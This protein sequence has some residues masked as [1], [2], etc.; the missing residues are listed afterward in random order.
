MP[1]RQKNNTDHIQDII[2]VL[3][4][5]DEKS[6]LTIMSHLHQSA[7]ENLNDIITN[8]LQIRSKLI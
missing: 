6:L 7:I 2:N 3:N 1:K 5:I 4:N 8:D